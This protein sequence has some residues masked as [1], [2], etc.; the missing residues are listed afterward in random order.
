MF[1]SITQYIN[2]KNIKKNKKLVL[3]LV[4]AILLLVI[5]G[6][7][8]VSK[9]SNGIETQEIVRKDLKSTI[10]AS[11]IIE[12]EQ[13]ATL[14]FQTFGMVSWVGV[15][16]GEEVKKW[17]ALAGLDMVQL[18]ANLQIARSNLRAAEATLERIHD[19]VKD[20]DDD[21]SYTQ[22]EIRTAAEVAKD[23]AYDAVLSAQKALS[24]STLIAP[25]SGVI[26]SISDNVTPGANIALTDTIIIADISRF[27]FVA[28]VDEVDY[29]KMVLGQKAEISLDAF[30]D[31]TFEGTVSYI[32]KAGVKTAGGGVTIPIEIQFDSNGSNMVVGL[33]GDV[34]FVVEKKENVLVVPK[35]YVSNKDGNSVVYVSE[36]GRQKERVVITG[37][38]TL[39]EVEIV[40]GLVQ[41][42]EVIL[43]NN[44]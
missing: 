23:N 28:Q 1:N 44:K 18:N 16:K 4:I 32:G 43:P 33:S 29:G 3:S 37:L 27:K 24:N 36:N 31:D 20:H 25:F 6:R 19:D 38:S 10:S 7:N 35:R 42:Q 9:N 15:T 22:K 21:E 8:I 39:S 30:S 17:Q 5:I 12:G 41:G 2:I 34:E 40:E 14:H 11:G 26:V 13:Q